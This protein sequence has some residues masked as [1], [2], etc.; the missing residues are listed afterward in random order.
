MFSTPHIV[1]ID[2]LQG[3]VTSIPLSD[4]QLLWGGRALTTALVSAEVPPSSHALGPGNILVLACGP[5]AGTLASSVNRL[6]IGAKSPLTGGVKESNAGG[7][8]AYLMGRLGIRALVLQ[9]LF[10]QSEDTLSH[11]RVVHVSTQG[12][13][14]DSG[15]TWAGMGVYAKAHGL[16]AHYGKNVGLTLIGPSGEMRMHTAGI[17]NADPEGTPSRFNGRGGLGAV[18][19]AKGVQ[20]IVWDAEGAPKTTYAH[21]SAFHAANKELA[22]TINT[23]P[24]TAQTYRI[25]GTAA[26]MDVTY[27]LG[28]L[29]TRNF[30]QGRFAAKDCIN[31]KALHDTILE[32]G[33]AGRISHACMRGCLIRCSNIYPDREGQALCSPIEYE[34]LGM[35]GSNLDVGNLDAV[36]RLNWLCNDLGC[37]TIELG[38]ALGVAMA[39]GVLSF[40]DVDAAEKALLD[41]RQ[42]GPL[43]RILGAGAGVTGSALGC[44][45]VPAIKNQA[46]AAYDPRSLKG[47][48]VTYATSPQGADHTAGNTIRANVDHH[49]KVG[50]IEASRHSQIICA[51][52]DSLGCCIFLGPAMG[53]WSTMLALLQAKTGV[54]VSLDE[55]KAR[56]KYTLWQ[57]RDFNRRA[58]IGEEADAL[59]DFMYTEGLPDNE[60]VFDIST[61][62]MHAVW[63][64]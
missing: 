55:L 24:Q 30:S 52:L 62:E 39:A 1:R 10:P 63:E 21:A 57:E 22:C 9:G 7:T 29:P 58:G 53:D 20:A 56:A 38:A 13:R 59:P 23:T 14:L 17:A 2:C 49:T 4:E 51:V 36:A 15:A 25:Y 32:R 60:Q 45:Y 31:G 6:S 8:S 12:V 50:Q 64:E 46:M 48:G 18:M 41:L 43:G 40:G 16:F 34:N 3:Q 37:D 35:L 11:W 54:K 44:R 61:Q 27:A 19:G 47:L 33:G 42:G 28:A 26:T 5:L